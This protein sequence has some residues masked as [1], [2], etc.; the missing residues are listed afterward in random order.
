MGGGGSS[1]AALRRLWVGVSLSSLG[2]GL[3]LPYLL[4][5]LHTVR[6][7]TTAM[8]GLVIAYIAALGLLATPIIGWAVDRFGPGRI[9]TVGLSAEAIAVL[10]LSQVHGIESAFIIAT[11]M[12]CGGSSVWPPQSALLARLAPA[13]GRQ[14]VFAFQFLLLNLGMGIGG[15]IASVIADVHRPSSFVCLY[16]INSLA[17]V[18][19]ALVS[20]TMWRIGGPVPKP[21]ADA[22]QVGGYRAVARD[23]VL[24]RLAPAALIVLICGYGQLEVGFTAYA[25]TV[26]RVSPRLMGVAWAANTFTIVLAQLFMLRFIQ[27]RSR[28][29]VMS[30]A[31]LVWASCWVMAATAGWVSSAWVVAAIL[32]VALAVFGVGETLWSPTMP[33]LLN[34]LAPEHLR[35]RYNAILAANWTT[36]ATIGPLISGLLIGGG[37]ATWWVWGMAVGCGLGALAIS[38]VRHVLTPAQDGRSLPSGAVAPVAGSVGG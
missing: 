37:F 15:L 35:G 36:A 2:Q 22:I 24:W 21:P 11:F 33:A 19:Y 8:A 20:I 31:G 23:R 17:Y 7:L 3:T 28:V 27:G 14:R 12:A 32:M 6:G 5:Y 10:L 18:G 38:R 30:T 16:V 34:D 13:G 25:T 9:L 1:Q 29:R 4:V 26:L